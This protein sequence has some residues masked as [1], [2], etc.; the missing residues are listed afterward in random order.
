MAIGAEWEPSGASTKTNVFCTFG[1]SSYI[2]LKKCL[3]LAI[4]AEWEFRAPTVSESYIALEEMYCPKTC[5]ELS[6]VN[7]WPV[8]YRIQF[9]NFRAHGHAETCKND[10]NMCSVA[11][12]TVSGS[13]FWGFFQRP[14][15]VLY[16]SAVCQ[17]KENHTNTR[18]FLISQD[19]YTY[20][21]CVVVGQPA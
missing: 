6:S 14:K 13:S 7:D 2:S 10:V 5:L 19:R 16:Y 21:S 4:A 17:E 8:V 20:S 11:A 3:H 9:L 12:K 15:P 18:I 1:V